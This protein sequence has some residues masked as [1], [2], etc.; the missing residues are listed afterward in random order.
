MVRVTVTDKN[1]NVVET[2]DFFLATAD[3]DSAAWIANQTFDPSWTVATG[4]IPQDVIDERYLQYMDVGRRCVARTKYL[5]DLKNLQ[6]SD[7]NTIFND[8]NLIYIER[9]FLQGSLASAKAALNALS[10]LPYLGFYSSADI[11][12]IVSIVDGSGLP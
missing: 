6:Q 5:T 3:A 12:N 9:L 10:P 1:G 4:A 8:A 11:A 7:L 2:N